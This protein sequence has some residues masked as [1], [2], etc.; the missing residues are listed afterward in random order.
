MIKSDYALVS[1]ITEMTCCP[2]VLLTTE[3]LLFRIIIICTRNNNQTT[4]TGQ[5]R[6]VPGSLFIPANFLVSNLSKFCQNLCWQK[7]SKTGGNWTRVE[8]V[9]F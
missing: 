6:M 1:E 7:L 5:S 8:E 2:Q 9:D 3:S 4:G